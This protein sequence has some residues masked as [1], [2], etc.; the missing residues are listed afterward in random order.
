VRPTVIVRGAP[1]RLP[2][3]TEN[4]LLRIAQ[5]AITNALRHARASRVDVELSYESAG[6]HLRVRDDGIGSDAQEAGERFGIQGMKERA[7][8]MNAQFR[9]TSKPSEGTEVSVHVDA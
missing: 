5:E 4:H 7:A 8:R 9:M 1:R 3:E 2:A 6:V